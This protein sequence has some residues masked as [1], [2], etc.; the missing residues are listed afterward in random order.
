VTT[1]KPTTISVLWL[2]TAVL[3]VQNSGTSY[4]R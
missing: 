3:I 1:E 4:T 2:P